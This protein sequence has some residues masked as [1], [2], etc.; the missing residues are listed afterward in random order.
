MKKLG[1]VI[2]VLVIILLIVAVG[3]GGWYFVKKDKESSEKIAELENKIAGSNDKKDEEVAKKNDEDNDTDKSDKIAEA[4]E[5]IR[6]AL[7]DETWIFRNIKIVGDYVGENGIKFKKLADKNNVPS[8]FVAW[9]IDYEDGSGNGILGFIVTY[10]GEDVI[11]SKEPLNPY[12][13]WG[14]ENDVE[15]D[16]K[17]N[18]A[19]VSSTAEGDSIIYK[20]EGKE[21]KKI[22]K[23]VYTGETMKF[24]DANEKEIS[25]S[26]FEKYTSN[27]SRID[28]E[29]NDSNV[30]KYV[31]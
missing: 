19:I 17:N 16:I 2:L 11:V 3:F 24:Y 1:N 8:Y 13:D 18:Y 30:D 22:S 14:S 15:L 7:K 27:I 10:D 25:E 4:N 5:A 6:K 20:I 29:L 28:I 9:N 26:Q 21:F 23:S 31:K 12:V